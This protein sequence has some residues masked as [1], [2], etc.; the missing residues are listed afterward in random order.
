[1]WSHCPGW[2]FQGKENCKVEL[3]FGPGFDTDE[4]PFLDFQDLDF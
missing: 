3:F 1:M 4:D 2:D